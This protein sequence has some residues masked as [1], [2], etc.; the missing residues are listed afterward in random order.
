MSPEQKHQRP[1]EVPLR[2]SVPYPLQVRVSTMLTPQLL[3]QRLTQ[4]FGDNG[5]RGFDL[6]RAVAMLEVRMHAVLC[7][8]LFK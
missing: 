3:V 6:A 5:G 1:L 2:A 7:N 4:T 8:S